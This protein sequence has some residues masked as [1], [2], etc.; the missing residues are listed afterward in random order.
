MLAT[1]F[2]MQAVLPNLTAIKFVLE[3]KP[4]CAALE[5]V[6]RYTQTPHGIILQQRI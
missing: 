4:S 5:I 2:T 3:A 6:S 1:H